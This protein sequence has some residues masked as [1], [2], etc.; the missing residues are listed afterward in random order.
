MPK[1]S[2][3]T[4]MEVMVAVVIVSVVIAAL[5]QM[6]GN[7]NQKFFGIK[8]MMKTTQYNSFLLSLSNKYGFESSKIDMKR[9]VDEFEL[10]S[11]LRRRLKTMKVE[12]NYEEL[13]TI[14]TS[15][16]E[17]PSES[18]QSSNSGLVFEIGKTTLHAKDFSTQL[19]RVK[20]Q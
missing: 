12:I 9:L 10:E 17:D 5:L 1:R 8:K 7:T 4:L 15:E 11:D 2:A 13:T 3:F 18:E 19:I 6:Q 20:I 16:F 14:D